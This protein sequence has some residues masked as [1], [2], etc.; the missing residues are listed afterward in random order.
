[1]TFPPDATL[2]YQFLVV[3]TLGS[4]GWKIVQSSPM[5]IQQ[6]MD[7]KHTTHLQ[8]AEVESAFI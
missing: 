4:L 3:G 8:V 2:E 1:M 7:D 6:D 5:S